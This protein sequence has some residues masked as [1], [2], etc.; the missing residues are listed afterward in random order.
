MS[1]VQQDSRRPA[2]GPSLKYERLLN[3]EVRDGFKRHFCTD[4]LVCD[5]FLASKGNEC[6]ILS[7]MACSTAV[8]AVI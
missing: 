5:H 2:G 7:T 6:P 8:S 3:E 4:E 1:L